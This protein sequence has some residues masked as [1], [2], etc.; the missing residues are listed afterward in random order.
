MKS[1]MIFTAVALSIL[2]IGAAQA[3][4]HKYE[5][6]HKGSAEAL[7]NTDVD[8]GNP[9]DVRSAN[10]KVSFT[11][12]SGGAVNRSSFGV[13]IRD[14][15]SFDLANDA[16]QEAVFVIGDKHTIKEMASLYKEDPNNLK[17]DFHA[18]VLAPGQKQ[19]FGWKFDTFSTNTVYAAYVTR[20][21]SYTDKMMR[22]TVTPVRDR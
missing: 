11:L 16:S 10:R 6:S 3:Q 22:I 13:E 12:N 1:S 19:K 21:G 7:K 8:F 20:D 15:V 17:D 2:T 4:D 9:A 14:Q 5:H 18:V